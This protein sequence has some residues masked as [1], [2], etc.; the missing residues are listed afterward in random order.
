[1]AC[2][3]ASLHFVVRGMPPL[4]GRC[5]IVLSAPIAFENGFVMRRRNDGPRV[6]RIGTVVAPGGDCRR[7][8]RQR[9]CGYPMQERHG[10]LVIET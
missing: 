3:A 9:G 8:R 10:F 2:V 5:G 4:V 6:C 7:S 1:M